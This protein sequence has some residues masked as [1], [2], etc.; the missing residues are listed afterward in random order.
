MK[1]FV[2]KD[3]HTA[4]FFMRNIHPWFYVFTNLANL[5]NRPYLIVIQSYSIP[6]KSIEESPIITLPR[7]AQLQLGPGGKQPLYRGADGTLV[8]EKPDDFYS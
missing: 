3:H 6:L 4:I 2:T 8:K 1:F 7:S 5:A